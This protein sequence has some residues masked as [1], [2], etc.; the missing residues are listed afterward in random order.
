VRW[1]DWDHNGWYHRLLLAQVPRDATR[2]LD[3][4]CGAGALARRLASR[5]SSV[6]A[7]DRSPAMIAAPGRRLRRT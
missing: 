3:V 6:D 5:V 7:V 1:T 2:V 4:G